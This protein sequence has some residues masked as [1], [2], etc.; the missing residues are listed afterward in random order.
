MFKN[1]VKKYNFFKVHQ[2]LVEANDARLRQELE[3]LLIIVLYTPYFVVGLIAHIIVTLHYNLPMMPAVVLALDLIFM[4]ILFI[5]MA[6]VK[7]H[8]VAISRIINFNLSICTILVYAVY[9]SYAGLAFWLMPLIIILPTLL[10]LQLTTYLYISITIII[11][12]AYTL[13]WYK[14]FDNNQFLVE[15]ISFMIIY[16]III[17][18]TYY[19]KQLQ[20]QTVMHQLKQYNEI[21]VQKEEIDKMYKKLISSK[22]ELI[23]KNVKLVNYTNLI[24]QQ[25]KD[26]DFYTNY[27][28]MTKLPNRRQIRTILENLIASDKGER[29]FAFAS[30]DL[31]DFK[32]VNDTLGHDFG[33]D[34]I[35]A[36][37]K[38]LIAVV[39]SKDVLGRLGGDEFAIIIKRDLSRAELEAYFQL[40]A[41]VFEEAIEVNSYAVTIK[42]SIG[43]A[44]YPTDSA[45][46]EGIVGA[47]DTAMYEA[48]MEKNSHIVFFKENMRQQII[49]R[50]ER[51]GSLVNALENEQLFVEFQPLIDA[52]NSKIIGF[53][54]LVRW[55]LPG[56]GLVPP[57]EFI[58]IAEKNG[59][60][61]EIT[62]FVLNKV[63]I[64]IKNLRNI[65]DDDFYISI[66]LSPV[67]FINTDVIGEVTEIIEKHQVDPQDIVL[68]ITESTYINN[69]VIA[70]EIINTFRDY[71]L[72]I[73]I[74]DF[75]TGYSSLEQLIKVPCD[76]VKI[77]RSFIN[78]IGDDSNYNPMFL[79]FIVD[80]AKNLEM[81]IVAEGVESEAQ[82]NF[83]RQ[84]HCD[85]FQ[86]YY[87]SRPI[88]LREIIEEVHQTKFMAS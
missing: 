63:C 31:D 71:G 65:Y 43:I 10:S 29:V 2:R 77:D 68:E 51:E 20:K 7:G 41:N 64:A 75:G 50:V 69:K 82:I 76:I 14:P 24:E 34:L 57:L 46:V 42:A 23:E 21:V 9:Y 3:N 67:Q 48:K 52:S 25:T 53:E 26:V 8:E 19:L 61:A 73:A 54:A 74:D 13:V 39:H 66:N 47:A 32:I 49:E 1:M 17:I 72:K 70:T 15:S 44:I 36:I 58:G 86:G 56:Q 84:I 60:I 87:Y 5:Y 6:R 11:L 85:I 33:D 62:K 28:P 30:L 88:S 16:A 80:L 81:K 45:N 4:S 27:D 37:A 78:L 79:K 55:T 12:T 38:N 40:I 18:K 83:L 22:E 35:K 59:L